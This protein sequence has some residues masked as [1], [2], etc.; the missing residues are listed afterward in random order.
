MSDDIHRKRAFVSDL[1]SGPGWKSK[2][3]KMSDK[4]VVA[5]YLKEQ[6]KADT[7]KPK[8]EGGDEIPF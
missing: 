6:A 5:I 2:V 7:P 8:K 1:Y 3:K 4:Q